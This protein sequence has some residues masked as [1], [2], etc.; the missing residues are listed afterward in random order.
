[1]WRCVTLAVALFH[2][3][4]NAAAFSMGWLTTSGPDIGELFQRIQARLPMGACRESILKELNIDTC[5][6]LSNDDIIRLSIAASNCHFLDSGLKTYGPNCDEDPLSCTRNMKA[7]NDFSTFTAFKLDIERIC[8]SLE[9]ANAI[10][11]ARDIVFAIQRSQEAQAE[12]LKHVNENVDQVLQSQ[13]TIEVGLENSLELEQ[14]LLN[15][16]NLLAEHS[17]HA[18]AKLKQ[19][20]E[21]LNNDIAQGQKKIYEQLRKLDMLSESIDDRLEHWSPMVS[22]I[23]SYS[24]DVF[25]DLMAVKSVAFYFLFLSFGYVVTIPDSTRAVRVQVFVVLAV[26]LSVESIV[27]RPMLVAFQAAPSS[28]S[29]TLSFWRSIFILIAMSLLCVRLYKNFFERELSSADGR[30][31][32]K[33]LHSLTN[34]AH[35][36]DKMLLKGLMNQMVKWRMKHPDLLN[37][38]DETLLQVLGHSPPHYVENDQYL[39]NYD[40]DESIPAVPAFAELVEGEYDEAVV[41]NGLTVSDEPYDFENDDSGTDFAP[42]GYGTNESWLKASNDDAWDIAH[43]RD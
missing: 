30:Q 2:L 9:R 13:Q 25:V 17:S 16:Q 24:K 27:L 21:G 43:D 18:I 39:V 12:K 26:C 8:A 31:L 32:L 34:D 15:T 35:Y 37:V 1:M 3:L 14:K 19:E 28:I 5:E 23:H 6:N 11:T 38:D 29:Q 4:S 20:S 33:N 10:K 40:D 42:D 7:N 22:T 36:H 41:R